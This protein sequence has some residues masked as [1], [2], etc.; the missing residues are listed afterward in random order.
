VEPPLDEDELELLDED[1]LLDELELELPPQGF[2]TCV[3]EPALIV[4]V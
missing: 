3:M 4:R 1:E 2:V